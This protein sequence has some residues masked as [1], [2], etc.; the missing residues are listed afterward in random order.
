MNGFVN[1]GKRVD[2]CEFLTFTLGDEEY[3][4]DILA[5]QEIRGYDPVTRIAGAPDFIKGVINLRGAIVPIVDM[6]IKL[7]LPSVTYCEFTVVI[8][9]A[10]GERQMGMVVDSVSDVVTL[11]PEQIKPPPE[12]G[13]AIDTRYITGLATIDARMVI[14]LD[15]ARLMT[16]PEMQLMDAPAEQ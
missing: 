16:G 4:V 14:V 2:T 9:L 6:R 1:T 8:I 15:I 3:A 12:L 7:G 13:A 10:I 11:P 5:V